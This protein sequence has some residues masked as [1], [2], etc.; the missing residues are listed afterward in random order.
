MTARPVHY[1]V[2]SFA[3]ALAAVVAVST[4]AQTSALAATHATGNALGSSASQ[5]AVVELVTPPTVADAGLGWLA[6]H[7]YP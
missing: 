2:K 7:Y 1:S 3:V 4:A 6:I 5:G